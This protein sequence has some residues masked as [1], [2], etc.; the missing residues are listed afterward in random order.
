LMSKIKIALYICLKKNFLVLN[1]K[2]PKLKTQKDQIIIKTP[3]AGSS[4]ISPHNERTFA[5][6]AKM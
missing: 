5:I 6:Y 3:G 4:S 1:I 2:F